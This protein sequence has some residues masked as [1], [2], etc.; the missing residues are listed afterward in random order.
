MRDLGATMNI[1]LFH[2]GEMGAAVGGCLVSRGH[3]VVWAAENRSAASKKRANE[4]GLEDAGS[5]E[6]A[7]AAADVVLSVCPPSN[8]LELARSVVATGF[9]GIYVDANAISPAHAREIGCLIEQAGGRFV[10]GGIIGLPPTAKRITRLYLCGAEAATVAALFA[11]SQ[12]EA[13]VMDQPAGAASALKMCYAASSKGETALL[14][15]IRSLARYEGV[16]DALMSEWRLS[17]PGVAERSDNIARRAFK[18][19]RWAG[20]MEEIAES[21]EDAGLPSGFR[22]NAEIYRR[23]ADYKDTAQAPDSAEVSTRLRRKQQ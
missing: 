9:R 1:A 13:I 18:A 7:V 14:G 16:D 3:P 20:E 12:T 10:D 4:A 5:L 15:I 17:Q 19:W 2:P 21:F 11:G 6:R 23:L 22:A 8:A